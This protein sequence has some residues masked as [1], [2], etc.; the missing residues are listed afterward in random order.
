MA[1]VV[2]E[3]GFTREALAKQ[4]GETL[5][6]RNIHERALVSI[7]MFKLAM[8][9]HNEY[10]P[11]GNLPSGTTIEDLMLYVRQKMFV[12]LKGAKN[13]KSNARIKVDKE[14]NDVV[15]TEGDMPCKWTF[16]GWVVFVL[17]C[18]N[19]LCEESLSCLSD[20]G[21]D[22]PKQ[23]RSQARLKD[24]KCEMEQRR[25]NEE[26]NRGIC[27]EDQLAFASLEAATFK[28]ETKNVR[29]LI[30]YTTVEEGNALKSLELIYNMIE[31]AE[32]SNERKF[33]QRRKVS[34]MERI[35]ELT[36]RKRKLEAESDVLRVR[37]QKRSDGTFPKHVRI[38]KVDEATP[39]S[40]SISISGSSSRLSSGMKP[41]IATGGQTIYLNDSDEDGIDGCGDDNKGM[42]ESEEKC[43]NSPVVVPQ[44]ASNLE[45]GLNAQS[46]L[47]LN[48]FRAK[49]RSKKDDE[50]FGMNCSLDFL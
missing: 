26:G 43:Y 6:G 20:N 41:R 28:E 4:N 37:Q 8:K 32:D 3:R 17:F 27:A 38:Q 40:S 22:V 18:P 34:L 12:H 48:N 23:S 21:S 25:H 31:R 13:N 47:T 11:N 35:D 36:D 14:G 44:E 19:G 39:T 16:N 5:K 30:Y 10:C 9:Y 24:A 46:L 1:Y 42:K 2:G 15:L 45:R 50:D 7:A 33:L 49:Q 29:D